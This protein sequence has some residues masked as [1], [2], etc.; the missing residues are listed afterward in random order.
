MPV[1]PYSQ[2]TSQERASLINEELYN[3]SRPIT[4]KD[5]KDMTSKLFGEITHP[6]TGQVALQV[7]EDYKI[8]IHP[9]KD[10]TN[11]KNLFANLSEQELTGLSNYIDSLTITVDEE[12]NESKS[13]GTLRFGDIIPSTSVVLTKEEADAA[14]WFPE[15]ELI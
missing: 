6:T 12:G 4:V 3:L 13:W 7:D 11:L 5:E 9:D 10:I 8:R 14:G 2:W 15:E 1:E